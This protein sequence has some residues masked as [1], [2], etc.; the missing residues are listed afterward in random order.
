M[1]FRIE[2]DTM[3]ERKQSAALKTSKSAQKK[4]QKS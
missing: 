2:H 1:E 3:G 4:C